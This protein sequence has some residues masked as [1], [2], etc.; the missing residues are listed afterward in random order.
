MAKL[1]PIV[2]VHCIL[3][4]QTSVDAHLGGFRISAIVNN[5]A[6]NMVVL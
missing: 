3:L 2:Y 1:Y 4:N 6:I 5:A